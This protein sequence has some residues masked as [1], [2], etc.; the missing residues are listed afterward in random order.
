MQNPN[1]KQYK[2][3]VGILI[4]HRTPELVEIAKNCL[5]SVLNSV[6]RNETQIVLCDNGSTIRD[7]F[8]EQNVDT[9]I[10]FN[11]NRGIAAGWNAILKLSRGKYKVILGD[12]TIVHGEWLQ[13]LQKAMDMPQAG[14]ANIYVQHLPQGVGIVENYKWFSGACF[15]L[16]NKTIE[17][18]GYFDE[19][20]FPCNTEDW[21]YW[22]R[23]YRVGLKLYVNYGHTVQHL[24]GQTVHAPDLSVHTQALL[25]RLEDK[26]GVNPVPIFTGGGK[27]PF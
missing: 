6:D 23:T 24:E 9:Y 22:L 18:V 25:K 19:E 2:Y 27:M 3:T 20:I 26:Y 16:T 13:E 5:A 4:F 11:E 15:M 21:D 17:K 14:V 1:L 10:R 7:D 8:W 12:D